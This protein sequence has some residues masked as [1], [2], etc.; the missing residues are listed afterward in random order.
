MTYWTRHKGVVPALNSPYDK[1][2]VLVVKKKFPCFAKGGEL[3]QW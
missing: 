3:A 1:H 2:E